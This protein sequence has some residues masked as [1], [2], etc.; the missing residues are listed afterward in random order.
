MPTECN[1]ALF[2]FPPVEGRQV[3]ASFDGGA[4]TSDAGALLL[5]QTDRALRRDAV[6]AVLAGKLAAQRSDCAPLAGKSTLNRLELSRVEPTRYHKISHDAAAIESLMWT[7]PRVNLRMR[8]PD[9]GGAPGGRLPRV[10][11]GAG[12]ARLYP[13]FRW[14]NP[15]ACRKQRHFAYVRIDRAVQQSQPFGIETRDEHKPVHTSSHMI[16]HAWKV[17]PP[18]QITTQRWRM[19]RSVAPLCPTCCAA[20]AAGHHGCALTC[21][22]PI[23]SA[24]SRHAGFH[25]IA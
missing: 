18:A 2:E 5:G 25:G 17:W 8:P 9:A 6:L 4:I 1:P 7:A 3:V 13:I 21:Q 10:I 16:V 22:A 14:L 11:Y 19:F 12:V 15:C 24:S 23:C 20:F